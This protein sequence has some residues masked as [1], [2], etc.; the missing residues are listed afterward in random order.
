MRLCWRA[1]VYSR[2]IRTRTSDADCLTQPGDAA[3]DANRG[4][5]VKPAPARGDFGV[6][7]TRTMQPSV[8]AAETRL[9]IADLLEDGLTRQ[10]ARVLRGRYGEAPNVNGQRR[11]GIRQDGISKLHV[12]LAAVNHRIDRAMIRSADVQ[13]G[14]ILRS[15]DYISNKLFFYRSVRITAE[16]QSNGKPRQ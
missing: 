10:H 8:S 9:S 15:L 2:E 13:R 14:Q 7:G 6:S 3:G 5:F 11:H 12:L 1:F 16:R 4:L